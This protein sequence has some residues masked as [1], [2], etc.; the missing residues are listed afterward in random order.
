MSTRH[1]TFDP[2]Q[3]IAEVDY[4]WKPP[5][6]DHIITLHGDT[7]MR[8]WISLGCVA[9]TAAVLAQPARAQLSLPP[10]GP[11][12]GGFSGGNSGGYGASV[13]LD[14]PPARGG[15]PIPVQITYSEHGVGAAGKGWDVPLS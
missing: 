5:R 10:A 1:S 15:L 13:P 12:G 6:N 11:A 9:L 14:F 3:V 4:C 7:S 8:R 2:L